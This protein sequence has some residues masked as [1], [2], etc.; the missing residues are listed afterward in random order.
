M[1]QVGLKQISL[2]HLRL[3]QTMADQLG[4]MQTLYDSLASQLSEA[5]VS[6]ESLSQSFG[7]MLGFTLGRLSFMAYINIPIYQ[8]LLFQFP[9]PILLDFAILL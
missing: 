5:T 9:L 8:R 3:A 7:C 6:P 1:Q 4:K 2:N